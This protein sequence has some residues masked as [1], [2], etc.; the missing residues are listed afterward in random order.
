MAQEIVPGS[1]AYDDNLRIA[2][3]PEGSDPLSVAV[4]T[5]PT[6]KDLT[7]SLKAFNRTVTEAVIDDPRLSLK[8][9]LQ[10]RGRISE[11]LEVQYVFGADDDVAAVALAEGTK[12]AIDVRYSLAN[13]T[14]WLA[15]QK[16]DSITI[17]CGKQR[18]DAPTEN[19]VQT[20]TQTL[21]VTGVSKDD[22]V[23]VA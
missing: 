9:T 14:D 3:V 13:A 7:Y 10:K 18:K 5:G 11:T 16:V 1:V 2:F 20:V 19:G 21:F 8:Q 23:L 22:A 15:G 6:T 4:L 12:G 17:E